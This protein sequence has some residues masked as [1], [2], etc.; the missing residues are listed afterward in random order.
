MNTTIKIIL[1]VVLIAVMAG[2]IFIFAGNNK[3]TDNEK[4]AADISFAI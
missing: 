3:E 4:T 2:A 1:A